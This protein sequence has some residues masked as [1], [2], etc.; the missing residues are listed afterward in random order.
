MSTEHLPIFPSKPSDLS[1]SITVYTDENH[2]YYH[3]GLAMLFTHAILDLPSFRLISSQLY[4]SGHCKQAQIAR[5]F[6]VTK[7]SVKRSVKKLSSKG[8]ASLFDN[9][10]GSKNRKPRV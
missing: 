8:A 3:C 6:H 7:E 5:F 9:K 1:S 2:V 4:L 10:S